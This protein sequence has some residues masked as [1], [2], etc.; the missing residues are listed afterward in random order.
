MASHRP[1]RIDCRNASKKIYRTIPTGQAIASLAVGI[2]T[3]Y[4]MWL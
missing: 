2:A 3:E 4:I 1:E